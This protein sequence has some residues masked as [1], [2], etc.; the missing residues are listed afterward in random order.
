[1]P[2]GF[3]QDLNQAVARLYRVTLNLTGYPTTSTNGGGVTPNSADSF[4]FAD[5]PTTAAKGLLRAQGNQRWQNVVNRLSGLSD[6][7]I[8]DITI[9]EA[10]ADAQATALSFTVSYDR[11]AAVLPGVLK[12]N[13]SAT[14]YDG[15]TTVNST[16][17]AIKDQVARGIGDVSFRDIFLISLKTDAC[18]FLCRLT[19]DK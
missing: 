5:L 18:L 13:G 16:S 15:S 7:K 19:N 17:L 6:C 11:D 14:G 2:S 8:L 3:Q 9:T 10:N 4:P 12:M 1:M